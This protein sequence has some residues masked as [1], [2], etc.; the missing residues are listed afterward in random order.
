MISR[1][2]FVTALAAAATA[3]TTGAASAG[4]IIEILFGDNRP[5]YAAPERDLPAPIDQP[6]VRK[7][8]KKLATAKSKK[9]GG[10]S[11]KIDPIYE[12][13][14]V[15]YYD[16]EAPGT[17]V[18]NSQDKFLFLV[19]EGNRARRY[20]V[21]IGKEGLGWTGEARIASKVEWPSWT[22]TDEMIARSPEH[23]AKYKDGMPGGPTNPL[24]ARA[25]YLYQGKTDTHI[26]I[27]G[28]TQPWTIG[29]AA[30]N[31]C[32]R[33]VNEHVVDLY[34]RVRIGTKVVV[35]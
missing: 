27:H 32:F 18:I 23:Y 12:P 8:A 30:S 9:K 21:A 3:A 5:I 15:E 26:R 10:K 16:G 35:L 6:P 24:G 20:G 7:K 33:M 19:E 4:S 1:R 14:E 29:S 2:F 11:Y 17:I 22:P 34:R 25:M 31:G 13:Q 28:T